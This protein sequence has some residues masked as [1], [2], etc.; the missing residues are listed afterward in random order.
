VAKHRPVIEDDAE[1]R[2]R[3]QH[4]Q[5]DIQQRISDAVIYT[6]LAYRLTRQA[7]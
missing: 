6:L 3:E 4:E 1:L 5:P 7:V 2:V